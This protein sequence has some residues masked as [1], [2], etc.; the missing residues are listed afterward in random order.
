[1]DP[2][3]ALRALGQTEN[4][5]RAVSGRPGDHP[6]LERGESQHGRPRGARRLGRAHR[7]RRRLGRE[8]FQ[9]RLLEKARDAALRRA[10]DPRGGDRAVLFLESRGKPAAGAPG[11]ER[12][13]V[14]RRA[15]ER[16]G[17]RRAGAD[18]LPRRADA[19]PGAAPALGRPLQPRPRRGRP[20]LPPHGRDVAAVRRHGQ[21][22]ARRRFAAAAERPAHAARD[23]ALRRRG[24]GAVQ[25]YGLYLPAADRGQRRR[26]RQPPLGVRAGDLHPAGRQA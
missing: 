17:K 3:G 2:A 25:R 15:V 6:G 7:R 12:H 8:L 21:L 26:A 13:A 18:P 16:R 1:M 5:L 22:A 10:A 11:R 23:R 9:G 14:E 24:T 20:R 19:L 4:P